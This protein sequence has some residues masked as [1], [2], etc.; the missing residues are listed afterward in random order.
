LQEINTGKLK[1]I[2]TKLSQNL[3]FKDFRVKSLGAYT[4]TGS[5]SHAALASARRQ[6]CWVQ[7]GCH[8]PESFLAGCVA[9][10]INFSLQISR[11]RDSDRDRD[12]TCAKKNNK[13]NRDRDLVASGRMHT[14]LAL[15]KLTLLRRLRFVE[16][17]TRFDHG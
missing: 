13:S 16:G 15:K 9:E 12:G 8:F 7:E 6:G 17:A 10:I 2:L 14:A 3:K 5:T 11:D 1:K 4:R